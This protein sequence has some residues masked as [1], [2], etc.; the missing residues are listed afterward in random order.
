LADKYCTPM[1]DYLSRKLWHQLTVLLLDFFSSKDKTLQKFENDNTF[2]GMYQNVVLKVSKKLNELAVA[3]MASLVA[4][5]CLEVDAS[6]LES[7]K[8]LLEDIKATDTYTKLFA[9]SK[10]T[11]LELSTNPSPEVLA[12]CYTR[13]QENA[14]LLA[15]LPHEQ[16]EATMLINQAHYEASMTY[17]KGVGPPEAFYE[18]AILY[19]NYYDQAHADPAA[20]QALA[21]DICLAA[22]V[23]EG[24]YNLG[25]VVTNPVLLALGETSDAWLLDLLK[26]MWA[27]D[28]AAYHTMVKQ[29]YASQIAGQPT[30]ANATA[31]LEEKMTLCALLQMVFET[32]SAER[33]LSF[34]D[35]STRLGVAI[36]QVEWVVMRAFS[37]GLL[38][39][40]INQ[41]A[42]EVHISWMLPRVLDSAQMTE[43][44]K[45]FEQW[46][47]TVKT[48]KS[49]IQEQHPALLA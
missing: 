10:L 17:Y 24:V 18:Q 47:D 15:E 35:I 21:V 37:V 44:A 11:L 27:G 14:K 45:R 36:D 34:Q 46:A 2:L 48:T 28:V 22:L 41:V 32:P 39:G 23:G 1:V 40:S 13:I 16:N 29:T 8:K 19:L 4:V 7:A 49:N 20:S 9:T 42:Q 31:A 43:L 26:G 38:K 3:R 33:T 25:Q 5:A 12:A 6:A 30:L